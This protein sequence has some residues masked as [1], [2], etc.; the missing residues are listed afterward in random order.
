MCVTWNWSRQSTQDGHI[1]LVAYMFMPGVFEV[2]SSFLFL[3]VMPGATSS[4]F[5]V[6]MPSLLVASTLESLG[7]QSHGVCWVCHPMEVFATCPM[8]DLPAW[9]ARELPGDRVAGDLVRH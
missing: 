6:A 3:V 8:P 1:G 5:L 2:T 7:L 9:H 4:F